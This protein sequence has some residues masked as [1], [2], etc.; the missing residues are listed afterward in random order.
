KDSIIEA[1]HESH[2]PGAGFAYFAVLAGVF[3]TAFYSFRMYFL[4]FHGKERY[5]Q[6]PDA[7]HDDHGHDHA[8]GDDHKPHE[9][10]WVVTV[11][12]VLLAIPSVVIGFMTIQP[13][14][15]G[16]FFKDAII[17]DAARHPA[18]AELARL[19][20]GPVAMALHALSTAPFW[21]AL[22]GVALSW[23]M[24]MVNPALPAAIKARCG[25]I[26]TL[27]DNKYYMDWINE[28][29]LAR[30]ARGLGQGLW[31]IGD[32]KFID[33]ALVNGSWRLVGWVAGVARR[34]QT[35]YIYHYA[36]VMLV[37]VIV[38]MTWFVWRD[39]FTLLIK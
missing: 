13:M 37:G 35:G 16:D 28:R 36:L 14:L 4:V 38:L 5:D 7:H 29:L 2:L 22:A 8:H 24:Y 23:Y 17:V 18:M 32:E 31:K 19:F 20:H 21:L 26:Y 25:P 33:G 39:Y 12:L 3:V 6:N 27:L 34:L 11:P 15:F 1:V 9:S 30:G 10:P